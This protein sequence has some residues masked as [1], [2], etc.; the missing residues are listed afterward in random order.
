MFKPL[1]GK[2]VFCKCLQ[3]MN[4]TPAL[5][6]TFACV[7]LQMDL[8]IKSC[9]MGV[10][11]KMKRP[12]KRKFI[13]AAA[14]LFLIA[15]A[16]AARVLSRNSPF[17]VPLSLL[18]SIIYISLMTAWGFSVRARIIQPQTRRYLSAISALIVFW[19][20]I[21]TVK[22]LFASDITAERY[23]WY[24]YYLPLLFIPPTA[25]F[26]ALSLGKGESF[27]LP[28]LVKLLY[29]PSLL[30]LLLVLTNDLHQLVFSFPEGSVFS[31][32]NYSYSPGFYAVTMWELLC[33]GAALV[34]MLF[35]CRIPRSKSFLWVPV[36]PL[37][38]ILLYGGLYVSN[39]YFLWLIAGDITVSMSLLIVA[40]FESCIA[41]GLIQ[42]NTGYEA[43]FAVSPISAQITDDSFNVRF[44]SA[45]AGSFPQEILSKA[46]V[47]PFLLG[48]GTLLKGSKLHKGYVFWQEDISELNKIIGELEITQEELRDTGDVLKAESEQRER[49]LRLEEENRLYDLV[50][51]QTVLQVALLREMLSTL[52]STDDISKAKHILGKIVVIGTYIKRK[53]NLIFVERQKNTISAGEL[54]LCLGES[55]ASLKLC[56]AECKTVLNFEGQL[57]AK[58]ANTIYDLF[59]AVIEKSID[60]LTLLLL[61]A[62]ENEN[63]VTINI[64]ALCSDELS[65]LKGE[66]KNLSATRDDDDLWYLSLKIGKDG[67]SS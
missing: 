30:L 53:S 24:F 49:K 40:A 17:H 42:S 23:L 55:A 62:Q 26:V 50:E 14:V 3:H 10:G 66:F 60:S 48:A 44:S 61:Y 22:Y 33:A 59:E 16:A 57:S 4:Y 45:C 21:R 34:I 12:E 7:I 1:N 65:A 47:S 52:K 25:V 56:G 41:C 19:L 11:R 43:L 35:K 32:K 18:R 31:D 5:K 9:C 63:F 54:R 20:I 29:I 51:K 28:S 64:S 2:C 39:V 58:T 38:L 27:R 13:I 6:N 67:E 8:F 36:V 46:S 15:V 37:S